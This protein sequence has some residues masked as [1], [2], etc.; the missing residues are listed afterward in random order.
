MHIETPNLEDRIGSLDVGK[1]GDVVLYY[2]DELASQKK[3]H[4]VFSN[5]IL[6]AGEDCKEVKDF[7]LTQN[8]DYEIHKGIIFPK[9]SGYVKALEKIALISEEYNYGIKDTKYHKLVIP[10]QLRLD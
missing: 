6:V 1:N 5:G 9:N 3:I 4:A 8:I 7:Y 2:D 10:D